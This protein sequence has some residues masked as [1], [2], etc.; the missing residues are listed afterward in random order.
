MIENQK[1]IVDLFLNSD[2]KYNCICDVPNE[3]RIYDS[4]NDDANSLLIEFSS[5]ES[6]A[7][8]EEATSES[9]AVYKVG[10]EA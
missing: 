2:N 10:R 1:I 3:E 8:F 7:R 5:E 6:L 9:N 4:S